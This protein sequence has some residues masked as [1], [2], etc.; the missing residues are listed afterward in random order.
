MNLTTEV[1]AKLRNTKVQNLMVVNDRG[2]DEDVLKD[3]CN[4]R[5]IHLIQHIPIPLRSRED[6]WYWILE[7]KGDFSVKSCYRRLRGEAECREKVFWR[8]IW[9]MQTPSKVTNLLWRAASG[10]IT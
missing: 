8:K 6:T 2:W 7:D 9:G 10:C 5:D 4:E 3:V 1:Q